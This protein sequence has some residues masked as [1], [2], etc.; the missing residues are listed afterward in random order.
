MRSTGASIILLSATAMAWPSEWDPRPLLAR[1]DPAPTPAPT[2]APAMLVARQDDGETSFDLNFSGQQGDTAT[3]EE[4]AQASDEAKESGSTSSDTDGDGEDNED[5]DN[6][7]EESSAESTKT[8]DARLPAGG[9]QMI[10]P[11]ATLF[12]Q[13]YK[14]KDY[15]TF[16]WNYTSLSATPAAVD[17]LASCSLNQATYTIA[18]NVSVEETNS[19]VWDTG[20]Y[21]A[22]GDIPLLTEKYT[23]IIHDSSKDVDASPAAGYLGA[24]QQFTFGM[25][26]PQPYT[27][28][29]DFVCATC[30]GAVSAME[31]RTLG[32]MAG[33]TV[34]TVLSFGWFTGV[35]GLW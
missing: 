16:A 13:Y 11:A 9:I 24:W 23:L 15:V 1:R 14:I 21:Q 10:T 32:F 5:E 28:L 31:R 30:N 12:S 35:A 2:P 17:V 22:T 27:P 7:D 34:L 6:E 20:D 33:M 8:F 18:Q 4:S 25:Y 3:V 29:A 26:T 19:I